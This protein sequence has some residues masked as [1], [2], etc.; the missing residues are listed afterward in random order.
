MVTTAGRRSPPHSSLRL[1]VVPRNIV[2]FTSDSN[3]CL[4]PLAKLLF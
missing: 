2:E 4:L 1:F 3:S